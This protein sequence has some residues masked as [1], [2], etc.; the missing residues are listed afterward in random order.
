[1]SSEEYFY[2]IKACGGVLNWEARKNWGKAIDIIRTHPGVAKERGEC[3]NL[4]LHRALKNTAPTEVIDALLKA[5]PDGARKRNMHG[6]LPLHFA[7]LYLAPPAVISSLLDIYPEA[8][9]VKDKD[10]NLAFHWAAAMVHTPRKV[11]DL[12]LQ[13]YKD[14][15]SKSV[16]ADGKAGIGSENRAAKDG[17]SFVTPSGNTNE[18]EEGQ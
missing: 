11:V 1:M 2:F 9:L 14:L 12:L 8:C 5:Y 10:N 15:E 18:V 7:V 6:Y 4:P 17:N 16:L 13:T 3:E